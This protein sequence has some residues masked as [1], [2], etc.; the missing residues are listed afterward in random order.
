MGLYE[1]GNVPEIGPMPERPQGSV[2][3]GEIAPW[4]KLIGRCGSHECR[5]TRQ[6]EIYDRSNGTWRHVGDHA[7][8]EA[9]AFNRWKAWLP[10]VRVSPDSARRVGR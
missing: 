9:D 5:L 2:F 3:D 6:K 8:S 4:A 7:Q 1:K 10:T